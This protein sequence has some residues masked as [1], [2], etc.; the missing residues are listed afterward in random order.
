[1][2]KLKVVGQ[3]PDGPTKLQGSSVTTTTFDRWNSQCDLV[4]SSQKPIKVTSL[5]TLTVQN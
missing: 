1:V 3:G 4:K 5:D 2:E